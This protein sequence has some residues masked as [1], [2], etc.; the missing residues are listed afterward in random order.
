MFNVN[1]L[2]KNPGFRME[3]ISRAI[4]N[5]RTFYEHFQVRLNFFWRRGLIEPLLGHNLHLSHPNGSHAIGK[6]AE[7]TLSD[8]LKYSY[9][10]PQIV[11]HELGHAI[12]NLPD[13]YQ[14]SEQYEPT[15]EPCIMASLD[16]MTLCSK[17]RKRIEDVRNWRRSLTI[18]GVGVV[19]TSPLW[20][21]LLVSAV[22]NALGRS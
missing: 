21:P 18:L 19:I 10:R 11:I 15:S 3:E 12:F 9:H 16:E 7:V 20:V 17:C 6:K 8:W 22:T 2:V 13:H 14:G 5:A 4:E 1:V